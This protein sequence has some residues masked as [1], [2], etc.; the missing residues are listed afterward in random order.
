MYVFD[1][2]AHITRM[3]GKPS[4]AYEKEFK[5]LLEEERKHYI[6]IEKVPAKQVDDLIQDILA[7]PRPPTGPPN[8]VECKNNPEKSAMLHV[9]W[10]IHQ[11]MNGS[12]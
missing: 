8:A 7:L 1:T 9:V 12:L 10:N 4:E 2:R 5:R 11:T 6:E 3:S